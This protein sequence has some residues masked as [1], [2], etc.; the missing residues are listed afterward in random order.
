M[1][2]NRLEIFG[3]K[4]FG[5]KT[6]VHFQD[7]MTA[8]VGPNGCGKSNILDSIQWVLGEKS[9]R[10][11]RSEKMEDVIFS[12][13]ENT[14]P[15]GYT[16]VDIFFNNKSRIL[17]V[18]QD[19]VII[20]RKLYRDGQSQYFLNQKKVMRKEIEETLMDTGL[21]K[22]SYSFM[23]QGQMDMILSSKPEERRYIFEE[24]AGIARYK[25]QKEE[26]FKKLENTE[27]NITRLKDILHELS[28]E[29][30]IKKNQS[31]KTKEYSKL[32][33]TRKLHEKK[34]T[35]LNITEMENN[36]DQFND[37]LQKQTGLYEK[38]RQKIIQLEEQVIG[39]EKEKDRLVHELHSIDL[40]KELSVEKIH[41]L[42]KYITEDEQRKGQ[43]TGEIEQI[44]IKVTQ[45]EERI[46][47][48]KKQYHNQKQL[49][50]ELDHQID[51]A[52]K[53]IKSI[54]DQING[55]TDT[56]GKSQKELTRLHS[57]LEQNGS[58]LKKLNNEKEVIIQQLLNYINE[59][60][61]NW[62]D[63]ISHI[64]ED[65]NIFMEEI[66]W[67]IDNISGLSVKVKENKDSID[68]AIQPI[69][70]H[71]KETN[72][73]RWLDKFGE[74]EKT[75]WK[76]LFDPSGIHSQKEKID[77]EIT[78]TEQSA[79]QIRKDINFNER[80]VQE[81]KE[82]LTEL[83][84]KK[85]SISGDVKSIQVQKSNVNEMEKSIH[86]QIKNE[87]QQLLY[88]KQRYGSLETE[89]LQ[90]QK[91]NS[92]LKKEISDLQNVMGAENKKLDTIRDNIKKLEEKKDKFHQQ[93][94]DENNR[95]KSQFEA[96]ND[97]EIRIGTLLGSKEAL[98]HDLYNNHN[99]TFD[100][101]KEE[102]KSKRIDLQK[103]KGFL[104]EIQKKI[105]SLGPINPLAIEELNTIQNLYDHNNEQLKDI[106]EAKN[107]VLQILKEIEDKSEKLFTESFTQI[108]NNFREVFQK[109]FN[110]GDIKLELTNPENPLISGI[111][112]H[113]QPP[114]KKPRSLKL[115]S[116]GEK[117]LTAISLMF[118]I[119]MVKSSPFCIMDEIDAPLDDQNVGRFL[120]LLDDFSQKTQFLLITHNKKTMAKCSSIF[121]VTMET[122]GISKLI[123]VELKK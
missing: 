54:H 99:I 10:S 45:H 44:Q 2:I 82:K 70:R 21:G 91:R 77:K 57:E 7:N 17:P 32:E 69:L 6:V 108:S 114:G 42:E 5:E 23:Q 51:N 19:E 88:F 33:E 93:I 56:I 64:E 48:L 15:S 43:I 61:V 49:F 81:N 101:L 46:E 80:L 78:K 90:I 30:S 52:E 100:E 83:H 1:F 66:N 50:L 12:G 95:S 79:I 4:S 121:G 3:F 98:I 119:Y 9:V 84:T 58:N 118:A 87:E 76:K 113:V 36:I 47:S 34:I 104:L 14:K 75:F 20:T 110:G 72:W 24:A 38:S 92:S 73:T 22:S 39:T 115:L 55:A 63:L 94:K 85:E 109:L 97:L 68:T 28:R 112:I 59:A 116:G 65:K 25:Q 13:T 35:Y 71:L 41:Q 29:L 18:D 123:S 40:S 16:Q 53:S 37:K 31:E 60:K 102:F 11:M 86:E 120:H 106:V 26:A 89:L 96:S 27:L 103:E 107:H 117:A 74:V 62:A 105:Q 8:V 122:P 111:D 67:I